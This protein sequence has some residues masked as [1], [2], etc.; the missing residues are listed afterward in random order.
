MIEFI[1]FN[2]GELKMSIDEIALC[3]WRIVANNDEQKKS[4]GS[5]Y[6]TL[7]DGSPCFYCD[8]KN[9]NCSKYIPR[10]DD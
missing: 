9:L 4:D 6:V 7:H 10:Y 1:F 2:I 8:G 5:S 3:I